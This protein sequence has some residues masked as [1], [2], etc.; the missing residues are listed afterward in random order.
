MWLGVTVASQR[1]LPDGHVLVR[2][3]T[4]SFPT[5]HIQLSQSRMSIHMVETF[6]VEIQPLVLPPPRPPRHAAIATSS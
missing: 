2:R 6:L 5:R 1:D 3:Q 4:L